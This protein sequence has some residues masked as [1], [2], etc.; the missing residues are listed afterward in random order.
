MDTHTTRQRPGL[1]KRYGR[2]LATSF[3]VNLAGAME[4]RA[5]FIVQVLG[6]MANNA[7]FALF[8]HFLLQKTG[9]IG[10]YTFHDIMFLWALVSGSYGLA[11]IVAG[12]IGELG[13]IIREGNLDTYLLQPKD[14]W[15]NI[16]ASKTVVSAWG[17][18]V[19]GYLVIVFL[20]GADLPHVLMF[21]CFVISGAAIFAAVS[22]AAECMAFAAGDS[23]TIS[24]AIFEFLLTF[25]LYPE[26]I[27]GP[28]LGWVFYSLIPAGFLAFI[29]R[30]IY[31]SLDWPLVP[32]A[33][34][35]A[36]VYLALS[37]GLFRLGLRRYE[38]GNQI[39]IRS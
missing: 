30:S 24:G 1:I 7:A 34:L 2:F 20:V 38:S 16:L 6:M 4:Y 13:S 9:S 12:N 26:K 35:A 39:G 21:T 10:G 33:M 5:N 25:S 18:L 11:H 27:F 8:W 32:L 14:P 22:A 37:Y 23:S 29:P 3:S 28:W 36:P 31:E 17:D 19:Y 15:I